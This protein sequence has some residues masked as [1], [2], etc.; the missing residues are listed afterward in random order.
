MIWLLMG[1]LILAV[2][3][4]VTKPLYEKN[5]PQS[6]IDTEVDD[7]LN[8][9]ADIDKKIAART[10]NNPVLKSTKIELQRGLI[11]RQSKTASRDATPPALLLASFFVIFSFSTLGLYALLGRPELTFSGALRKPTALQNRANTQASTNMPLEQLVVRLEQRLKTG[12][13]NLEGQLLLARTLMN[14]DQYNKAV[15]TYEKAAQLS[16]QNSE[17]LLEIERAKQFISQATIQQPPNAPGPNAGDIKAAEQMSASER[18]TMIKN[19]VEGLSQKLRINPND[20]AGWT[21]LLRARRVLGQDEKAEAEI[22][23]MRQVFNG[24][25]SVIADIL[26]TSGWNVD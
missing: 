3:L 12:G 13:D 21:R 14:L 11:T 22:K 10:E 17:I 23:R 1:I 9:I 16:G 20:K 15:T 7:Y 4:F 2:L 24:Q 19:M 6:S 8:H 5:S 25:D 26:D 18:N